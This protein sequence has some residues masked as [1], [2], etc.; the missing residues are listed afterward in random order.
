MTRIVSI[1]LL[2]IATTGVDAGELKAFTSDGCSS[3]P[4]GTLTQKTLW[5]KC[6]IAHDLAYWRGGSFEEREAADLGLQACV[7]SVGEPK[8]A[9]LMHTGVRVGGSP[10][11]LT[12]YRWGYGWPY[13]RGYKP[14]SDTEL[15]EVNVRLE[16]YQ[17]QAIE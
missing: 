6:C 7:Q 2:A 13:L 8:V 16:E 12:D 17:S 1:L 5:Q 3:F 11:F 10:Y 9:I 15:E 14:L 4:D